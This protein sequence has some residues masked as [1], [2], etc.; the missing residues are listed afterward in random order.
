MQ[1]SY[2]NIS[3]FLRPF[4]SCR[5]SHNPDTISLAANYK[6]KIEI[7]SK[8]PVF[9]KSSVSDDNFWHVTLLN[10]SFSRFFATTTPRSG[11]MPLPASTSSSLGA[12]RRWWSTL[13]SSSRTCSSRPATRTL[14][15]HHNSITRNSDEVRCTLGHDISD[16]SFLAPTGALGVQIWDLCLCVRPL[17]AFRLS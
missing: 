6:R 12:T 17:Y 5:S 7:L 4:R 8:L 2:F 14:R 10:F 1:A 16:L 15:H 9:C 13:T 3:Q 11:V